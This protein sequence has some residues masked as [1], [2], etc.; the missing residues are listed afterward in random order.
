M[1]EIIILV[2]SIIAGM[3]TYAISNKLKK[4]PVIGSAVVTLVAGIVF[5]YLSADLG[6]TLA[7]VSAC[8]SYAGMISVEN[9]LNVWEMAII[10]LIT[11]ILF[12]AAS[13]AYIGIGGKLGTMAAISCFSWLGFKKV[14]TG[15]DQLFDN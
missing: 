12:I 15:I 9:A 8:S 10:S 1:E 3:A 2:I 14:F 5:P 13:N 11:G 4:G 7:T 6:L